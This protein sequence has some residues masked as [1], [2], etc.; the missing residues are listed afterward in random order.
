M[1]GYQRFRHGQAAVVLCLIAL[2]SC[3]HVQPQ[4]RAQQLVADPAENETKLK[5]SQV[6]DVQIALG[7][8]LEKR[9]LVEQATAAY[10][11]ALK[12]DPTR[13]DACARLAVLCDQ[14]GRF[15]ESSELYRQALAAQPSNPDLYNDLGYGLYLRGAWAEA[16]ANL[17]KALALAPDH[18]RAHNNLGLVLARTGRLDEALAEFRKAGCSEADAH[19]NAAFVLTLERSWPEARRYYEHALAA[20]P[21]STS[22]RKGLRELDTLIVRAQPSHPAAAVADERG[23][24][25]PW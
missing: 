7:R 9:G 13:S 10:L 1:R 12:H 5:G 21:S 22:A 19:T 11:K 4:P 24:P 8:S 15:G 18:R 23:W 6:A 17:R 25:P 16:E 2:A 14:Q 20:D 3:Q